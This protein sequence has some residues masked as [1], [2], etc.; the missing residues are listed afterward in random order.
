MLYYQT[1]RAD[2]SLPNGMVS[3]FHGLQFCCTNSNWWMRHIDAVWHGTRHSSRFGKDLVKRK[4]YSLE[5]KKYLSY[6]YNGDTV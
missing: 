5:V 4:W 3:E 6:S 1:G 2:C